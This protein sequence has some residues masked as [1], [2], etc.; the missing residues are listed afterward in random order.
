MLRG[1]MTLLAPAA[2]APPPLVLVPDSPPTLA[3]WTAAEIEECAAL[4]DAADADRER[5]RLGDWLLARLPVGA[6][7]GRKT[8]TGPRLAELACLVGVSFTRLREIRDTSHSWPPA[9]RVPNAG[10]Y[11]HSA[12]RDGGPDRA[13]WRRQQLLGMPRNIRGRITSSALRRWR[14]EQAAGEPSA[15]AS[16]RREQVVDAPPAYADVVRRIRD[17]LNDVDLLVRGGVPELWKPVGTH[18]DALVGDL[19][20]VVAVL[21]KRPA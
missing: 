12:F 16:R 21:S 10:H 2:P 9:S 6:V 13:A 7:P 20:L 15:A 1:S 3:T 5:W 11:V 19:E 18:L 8:G 17:L 14:H 4:C